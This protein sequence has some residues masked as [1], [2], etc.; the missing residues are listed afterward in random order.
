[1]EIP[2][3]WAACVYQNWAT[4]L[5]R[6]EKT[7]TRWLALAWRANWWTRDVFKLSALHPPTHTAINEKI[8]LLLLISANVQVQIF[9]SLSL[10]RI[11]KDILG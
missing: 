3:R 4:S 11:I 5:P 6:Q 8:S 9:Q 2:W 7:N 10:D 1:M